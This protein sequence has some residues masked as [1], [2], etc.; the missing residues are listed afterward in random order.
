ML[1]WRAVRIFV[2]YRPALR[3]RTGVGEY[4]HEVARALVA[5]AP[6][7]ESLTLFSASWKDRLD[8]AVLPGALTTDHRLPVRVLNFAWHRLEW[9]T[10]EKLTGQAFEVA[11]SFHPLLAPSSDAARLVTIHDLDFLD[12]P[13]R[14]RAEIRRDYPALA[15]LHATRADH[16]LVNSHHT[17]RATETRLGV[18]ADRISVARPGAPDWP[19][20]R[21]EPARG[22]ILFLGTIEPRKNVGTLLD[23]YER[24]LATSP[25]APPLVLA[26]GS[27]ADAAATM[28]RTQLAPLVG[29]VETPGYVEA[30]TRLD[31]YRRALVFVMPSHTEGFGMTVLEAMTCGVPVIASARGGLPEAAGSA[32]RLVDPDDAPGLAAAIAEVLGSR[33]LRD[34]MR[35][36]G[37]RQAATFTWRDTATSVREAWAHA[38]ASRSRRRG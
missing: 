32:A 29:R 15:A 25:D 34:R 10:I 23:A 1:P 17:A 4:V 16:I 18:A 21:E 14:S 28:R 20:R 5:T 30:T 11:Q 7:D 12:H 22:C 6:V 27:T 38:I 36:D 13:E 2:D 35:E 9:P 31:L 3:E 24:L 33:A 19:R 26:G 8:P 37:W